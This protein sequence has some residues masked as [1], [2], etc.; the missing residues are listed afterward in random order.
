MRQRKIVLLFGGRSEEHEISLLSATAVLSHLARE[1]F[2]VYPVGITKEGKLY[3][4]SGPFDKIKTGEWE[5]DSSHLSPVLFGYKTVSIMGMPPFCPDVIFPVL[6]GGCGEDGRLQG[7]FEAFALPFVGCGSLCSALCMHKHLAKLKF[8]EAGIPTAKWVCI[9]KRELSYP[10]VL[11][12][13]VFDTLKTEALFI[14]PATG[15]SSI[16][17][18]PLYAKHQL[19]PLLR[20]AFRFGDEALVEERILGKECEVGIFF[21]SEMTVS[22]P[23]SISTHRDFYDFNAK[24]KEKNTRLVLPA[25]IPADVAKAMQ[26]YAK[27]AYI[28]LGCRHLARFDFFFSKDGRILLSE[29]NTLPGM[30]ERSLFPKMM[31]D[32]GIPFPLLLERLVRA[33]V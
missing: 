17:A 8:L 33:A 30:T 28:A 16:G 18:A 11:E 14:K 24:Y 29:V 3:S 32:Q 15:G 6:H 19:L 12:E 10:R 25:D 27:K 4:Y 31:A 23:A 21:D 22:R 26:D 1:Q 5:A 20:E 9:H 2:L 7:L 13:K